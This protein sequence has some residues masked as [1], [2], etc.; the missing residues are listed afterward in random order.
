MTGPRTFIKPLLCLALC[1][2]TVLWWATT[3][4][5]AQQTTA[6]SANDELTQGLELYKQ[7]N[8]KA[9]IEI[10]RRVVK[11]NKTEIAAW[12]ALALAYTRQGKPGDARKAYEKAALS[13]DWLVDQI[14]SS[15]PVYAEVPTVM[16]KY[17]ALLLMA[18]DSSQ[19]YLAM[20]SKPSRSKLEE[21]SERTELLRDYAV[22]AEERR[23]NPAMSKVYTT[24]EVEKK[25]RILA[26]PEPQYT[27]AARQGN[28]QG[29]V[30]IRAIFAFDGRVRGIRV[31]KGLPRGLT[32]KAVQAARQIKFEPA[33]VG[34]KPVSQ[35][36]QIEY[37]FNLY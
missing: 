34:G 15:T 23:A 31:V 5:R 10:L 37:N 33:T 13:G 7:G 22:L 9:A 6:A 1:A 16:E 3:A 29:T 21:W 35:Y 28:V 2:L 8:D 14:Y 20:T 26:R 27:E 12:Y 19:K 24:R 11:K 25:A 36:I 4:A 18:A 32:L 17:K 30:V